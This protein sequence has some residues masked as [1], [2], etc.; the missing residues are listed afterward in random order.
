M[1]TIK[2]PYLTSI[3]SNIAIMSHG[4]K[5][6]SCLSWVLRLHFSQNT[7]CSIFH[8]FWMFCKDMQRELKALS[9]QKGFSKSCVTISRYIYKNMASHTSQ[10]TQKKPKKVVLLGHFLQEKPEE[11]QSSP[12][13]KSIQQETHNPLGEKKKKVDFHIF[14][15]LRYL[16]SLHID[17]KSLE[18]IFHHLFNNIK[19]SY[20]ASDMKKKKPAQGPKVCSGRFTV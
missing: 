18:L 14:A 7:K 1:K 9:K 20:F 4:C 15:I 13:A 8:V 19:L 17:I 12:T 5:R 6:K 3:S 16:I 2:R 11:K 10:N